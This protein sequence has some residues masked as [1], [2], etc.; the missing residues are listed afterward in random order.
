[1]SVFQVI[2]LLRSVDHILLCRRILGPPLQVGE[3]Y[4]ILDKLESVPEYIHE[5]AHQMI[6]FGEMGDFD[7][8]IDFLR[9]MKKKNPKLKLT[10]FDRWA[11]L[12]NPEIFDQ[13]FIGGSRE[14]V[15]RKL[16]EGV[17]EFVG[18]APF[19]YSDHTD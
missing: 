5:G 19:Q 10:F 16:H 4:I 9:K 13:V 17:L 18:Y 12:R 6:A 7:I 8:A 2:V 14:D 11:P 15:M 1:M 3:E